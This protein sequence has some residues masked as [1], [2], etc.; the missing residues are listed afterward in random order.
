MVSGDK[1]TGQDIH[2]VGRALSGRPGV[3]SELEEARQ[4]AKETYR[5]ARAS[6]KNPV[7]KNMNAV[8]KPA[9]HRDR[10]NDYRRKE[11]H[12]RK[13]DEE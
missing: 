7:A 12:T 1:K 4:M 10:K 8:N 9:I 11:K 6:R 5:K 13:G 2:Q 3:A